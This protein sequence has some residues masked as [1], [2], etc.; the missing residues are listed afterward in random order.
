MELWSATEER[1]EL[2]DDTGFRHAL[3]QEFSIYKKLKELYSLKIEKFAKVEEKKNS[4]FMLQ[5]NLVKA[6]SEKQKEST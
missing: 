2:Y 1:L 5:Q 3:L 6:V 4:K